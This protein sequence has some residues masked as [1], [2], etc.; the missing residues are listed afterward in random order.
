VREV[1]EDAGKEEEGPG[2]TVIVAATTTVCK[3]KKII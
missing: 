1:L 2:V 3:M